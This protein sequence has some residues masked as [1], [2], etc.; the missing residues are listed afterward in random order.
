MKQSETVVLHQDTVERSLVERHELYT[1]NTRLRTVLKELLDLDDRR[2][3]DPVFWRR[4][5]DE[6]RARAKA[7]LGGEVLEKLEEQP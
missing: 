7:S 1:E 3:I 6:A 2:P 4:H 5:W